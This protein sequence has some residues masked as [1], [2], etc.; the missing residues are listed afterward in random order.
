MYGTGI[1]AYHE[2]NIMTADPMRLVILCYEGAIDSL[3]RAKERFITK[4]F[5]SKARA[6]TKA[7]DIINELME[8]LDFE[9][10]GDVAKSLGAMYNYTLRCILEGDLKKDLSR[11]DEAIRILEALKSA[12]EEIS[13]RHRTLELPSM[14]RNEVRGS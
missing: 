2:T 9:R 6:I 8:S 10:G 5:E 4:D 12:W 7:N 13:F 1:D 11:L 3:K 14:V